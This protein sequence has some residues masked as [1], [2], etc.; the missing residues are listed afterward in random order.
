MVNKQTIYYFPRK[1]LAE[2]RDFLYGRGL[3]GMEGAALWF[4]RFEK[5]DVYISR[6]FIP[7]QIAT[8]NF[9]G[10]AVDLTPRAHYT[11]VDN[12]LPGEFIFIR[13]H[14]HPGRAYHS[15]RD[16][17]NAIITHQF[18]ISVVVPDFAVKPIDFA[19][20]AIYRLEHRRGWIRLNTKETQRSFRI[21]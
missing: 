14:S 3:K 19:T 16:D 18:A 11:L 17:A 12:L 1:V 10:V 5:Q 15:T 6:V 7:E 4:G 8:K 9:F 13:V 2:T 20:C 21:V